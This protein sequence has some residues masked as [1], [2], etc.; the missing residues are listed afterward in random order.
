M[1]PTEAIQKAREIGEKATPGPWR[2]TADILKGGGCISTRTE[3]L[4]HSYA[5]PPTVQTSRDCDFIAHAR[6]V[7]S[8][9]LD[10][11]DAAEGSWETRGGALYKALQAFADYMGKET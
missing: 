7:H 4:F 10:I 5:V 8:L 9:L 11:A 1:T 6:N 3:D 2:K